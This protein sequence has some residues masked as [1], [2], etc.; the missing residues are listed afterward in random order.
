MGFF[1]FPPQLWEIK[2]LANFSKNFAQLVG[3]HTRG[4][5]IQNFPIFLVK[6]RQN[7]SPKITDYVFILLVVQ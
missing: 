4:K 1:N 7:F 3:V 5:K 6:K 2:N